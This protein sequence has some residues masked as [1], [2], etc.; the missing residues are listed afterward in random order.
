MSDPMENDVNLYL[1]GNHHAELYKGN[2][3]LQRAS[4]NSHHLISSP[5]SEITGHLHANQQK[6]FAEQ[7]IFNKWKKCFHKYKTELYTF[8]FQQTWNYRY[9]KLNIWG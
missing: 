4:G 6:Q 8:I 7:K 9:D 1:D 3:G 5:I 2:V